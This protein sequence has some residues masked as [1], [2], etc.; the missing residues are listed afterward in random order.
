VD[1]GEVFGARQPARAA[2]GGDQEL[3]ERQPRAGGERQLAYGDVQ[4]YCSLAQE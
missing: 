3:R 2:S 1:V 4:S